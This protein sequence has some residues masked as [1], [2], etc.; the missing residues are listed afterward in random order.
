VN[1]DGSPR[2]KSVKSAGV[3]GGQYRCRVARVPCN[4]A[5]SLLQKNLAAADRSGS[6]GSMRYINSGCDTSPQQAGS[7]PTDELAGNSICT[8]IALQG[9]RHGGLTST[10]RHPFTRYRVW[11]RLKRPQNQR[12][13]GRARVRVRVRVTDQEWVP[14][15][16]TRTRTRPFNS[17]L[18]RPKHRVQP[19]TGNGFR[20]VRA[21]TDAPQQAPPAMS[22]R[23]SRFFVERN[24]ASS[25]SK[26]LW[27]AVRLPL[28]AGATTRQP[29]P[30]AQ[31]KESL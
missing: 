9:S 27:L 21:G 1:L 17:F 14:R 24:L 3:S 16:R 25:L 23:V 31:N 5:E 26:R 15:T 19:D 22:G 30:T 12:I 20:C 11:G 6:V 2:R 7:R 10:V 18:S 4:R 13:Y 28:V 29:R 8:T